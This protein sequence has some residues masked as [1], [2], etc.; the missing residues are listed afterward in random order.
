[1]ER[2]SSFNYLGIHISKN[3]TSIFNITQQVKK[4]Q[5]RLHLLRIEKFCMTTK[6]LTSCI[7]VWYSN[8]TARDQKCLQR[9]V[10][11]AESIT[12][13]PLGEIRITDVLCVYTICSLL[14]LQGC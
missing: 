8:T 11:T 9:V 5:Q 13:T 4:A 1:M 12:R 2:V 7:T 6:F 14:T 10:K 3:L